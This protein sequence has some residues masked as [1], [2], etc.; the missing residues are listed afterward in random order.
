MLLEVENVKK[1]FGRRLN[2][3]TA[4]KDLS[5]TVNE[6]EFVAI[7]GESGSGKSTLLN[8]IATF[9]QP[10][11]GSITIHGQNL[12][13]LKHKQIAQFR[14][15]MLGF[16][17]Q[18]FNMLT[19]MTN[20]DNLLMPLVLSNEKPQTMNERVE[21]ISEELDKKNILDKYPHEVSGGQ[22]QRV[23][24]GRA[25]ITQP[26]LILADEPT[27]ALDSKTSED[28]MNLFRKM[29]HDQQT[30]L[31]VTHSTVDASFAKRVLFIKDGRVYHEIYRGEESR[32]VFQKRISESLTILNERA[33]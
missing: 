26:K 17:F 22:Q 21:V 28:I 6:G 13:Q 18:D 9:D 12:D 19:T 11:E 5:F 7:M 20:K 8:L 15:N 33:D 27:G 3:V 29:N 24:I 25:I 30:I 1:I 4:L 14:R 23:A 10:T 2:A 16:V 32:A 31:M